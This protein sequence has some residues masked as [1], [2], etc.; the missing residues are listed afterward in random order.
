MNQIVAAVA[1]PYFIYHEVDVRSD[2]KYSV[3]GI[4]HEIAIR[5]VKE[6]VDAPR[7]LNSYRISYEVMLSSKDADMMW[8]KDNTRNM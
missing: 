7:D 2:I 3:L 1:W 5:E 6:C 8:W 4:S